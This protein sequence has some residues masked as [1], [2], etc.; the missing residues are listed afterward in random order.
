[1]SALSAAEFKAVLTRTAE[2]YAATAKEQLSQASGMAQ[3]NEN[4]AALVNSMMMS[5]SDLHSHMQNTISQ[6]R[7][8]KTVTETTASVSNNNGAGGFLQ[9]NDIEGV[10]GDDDDLGLSQLASAVNQISAV[11]SHQ[12]SVMTGQ[13]S[14]LV[15]AEGYEAIDGG[16][17][18]QKTQIYETNNKQGETS[19]ND[20]MKESV[21]QF[22]LSQDKFESR[23]AVLPYEKEMQAHL[24]RDE[25]FVK[26]E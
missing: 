18:L 12:H 16:Q 19:V 7:G 3:P 4:S 11:Q 9:R 10:R 6:M 25:T 26:E 13:G 1:M 5:V 23:D 24:S 8:D 2:Q 22:G 21:K 20:S 14:N 15:W 17:N